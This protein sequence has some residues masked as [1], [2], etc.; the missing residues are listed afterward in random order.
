MRY[1]HLDIWW[2]F[3]LY[4]HS[5][6]IGCASRYFTIVFYLQWFRFLHIYEFL[7]YFKV[8]ID[9]LFIEAR[10]FWVLWCYQYWIENELLW[11]VTQMS[12]WWVRWGLF[13]YWADQWWAVSLAHYYFWVLAL[14][15]LLLLLEFQQRQC[16]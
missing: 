4:G 9:S 11:T 6:R 13:F 14:F 12:R 16:T 15:L 7:Y 8:M 10:D 2:C 5:W 1:A 3:L